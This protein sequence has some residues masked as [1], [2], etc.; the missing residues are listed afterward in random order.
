MAGRL[1][2]GAG[3]VQPSGRDEDGIATATHRWD[4]S[5]WAGRGRCPEGRLQSGS[6]V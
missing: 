1:W 3:L 5:A 6:L 4:T 2:H